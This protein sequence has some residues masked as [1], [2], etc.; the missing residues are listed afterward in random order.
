M[1]EETLNKILDIGQF[2][3]ILVIAGLF[4]LVFLF[5]IT[6]PWIDYYFF[7]IKDRK[8]LR[9]YLNKEVIEYQK[10][11]DSLSTYTLYRRS[12]RSNYHP[13]DHILAMKS[14]FVDNIHEFDRKYKLYRGWRRKEKKELLQKY[15][16][17]QTDA[18]NKLK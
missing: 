2:T 18:L 16:K 7:K 8:R 14:V 9:Q 6:V 10:F 12:Y 13:Q 1:K 11:V 17:I 5:K 15:N 3:P 4:L